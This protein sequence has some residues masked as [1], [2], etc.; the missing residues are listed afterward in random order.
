M[1]FSY[2]TQTEGFRLFL[3]PPS[4][5]VIFYGPFHPL[6]CIWMIWIHPFYFIRFWLNWRQVLILFSFITP[7]SYKAC[8]IWLL[9]EWMSRWIIQ[10]CTW[11]QILK[12][13]THMGW[14]W[15]VPQMLFGASLLHDVGAETF[16]LRHEDE[17]SEDRDREGVVWA[18][19]PGW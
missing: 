14:T 16:H 4:N 11:S 15:Q 10:K 2:S 17:N 8:W 19:R 12:F 6:Y 13:S 7:H 5:L 1:M 3:N 18:G 9:N